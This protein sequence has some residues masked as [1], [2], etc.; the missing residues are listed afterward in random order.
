MPRLFLA[1]LM[2]LLFATQLAAQSI[3]VRGT[4]DVAATPDMAR[5]HIGISKEALEADEAIKRLSADLTEVLAVLSDAGLG[6]EAVQTSAIRLDQRL[7][8]NRDGQPPRIVGFVASS[9]LRLTVDA[10]EDLGS[11]LDAV[12]D[13][14]VTQINQIRFD[15]ANPE[16][17][18]EQA[19]IKA[20]QNGRAKAET[21]AGA[22]GVNL[23]QLVELSEAGGVSAP[24][25]MEASMARDAG[26]PIAPGQITF[27]ASVTMRYEA[28]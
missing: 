17:F 6:A 23:G 7:D 24:I 1:T 5:I 20:V 27:S 2:A 22:A 21:Y 25:M 4:A 15:V 9:N 12:V 16:P 14:G 19:R 18:L 11:L 13:A 3:V 10:L 8:Y 26:V 28:E